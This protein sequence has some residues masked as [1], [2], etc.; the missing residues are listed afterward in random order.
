[1]AFFSGWFKKKQREFVTIKKGELTRLLFGLGY[2][3]HAIKLADTEYTCMTKKDV[4]RKL[5]M[6]DMKYKVFRKNKNDCDNF[7]LKLAAAFS[8]RGW[9][10]GEFWATID[11]EPHAVNIWIDEQKNVHFIEP[12]PPVRRLFLHS[13]R[14]VTLVKMC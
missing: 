1:M 8:G 5:M 11:G 13:I 7:V 2:P 10:F 9:A 6:I 3:F 4:D 12:Q 14:N